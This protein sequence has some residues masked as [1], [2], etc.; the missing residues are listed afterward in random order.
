MYNFPTFTHGLLLKIKKLFDNFLTCYIFTISII[1]ISYYFIQDL[2]KVSHRVRPKEVTHV[3]FVTICTVDSKCFPSQQMLI[4]IISKSTNNKK[5]RKTIVS[6]LNRKKILQTFRHSY[7]I[8][9]IWLKQQHAGY[10]D[11]YTHPSSKS[12]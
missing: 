9:L 10:K 12:N 2:K 4:L 5:K 1:N 6:I 11:R 7:T 3:S 8:P